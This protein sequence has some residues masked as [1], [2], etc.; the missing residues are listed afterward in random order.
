MHTIYSLILNVVCT[1]YVKKILNLCSTKIHLFIHDKFNLLQK[2]L[3]NAYT[4]PSD[5]VIVGNKYSITDSS[6]TVGEKDA[7]G[8][9]VARGGSNRTYRERRDGMVVPS[10]G[11]RCLR[12]H[13]YD[14]CHHVVMSHI[15]RILPWPPHRKP[16]LLPPPPPPYRRSPL[17]P[18][19]PP[20]RAYPTDPA[21]IPKCAAGRNRRKFYHLVKAFTDFACAQIRIHNATLLPRELD[22]R[23]T[24]ICSDSNIF[25]LYTIARSRL[26]CMIDLDD[27]H[28]LIY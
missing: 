2:F 12:K 13:I 20:S 9:G 18:L 3:D 16:S 6:P 19:F 28:K 14:M 26:T 7:E 4:S 1:R 25:M 27:M 11:Y 5:P 17:P 24:M 8:G 10:V 22:P 15:I 23:E 21:L